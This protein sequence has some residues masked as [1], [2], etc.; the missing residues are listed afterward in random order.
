MGIEQIDVASGS[1]GGGGGVVVKE[2]EDIDCYR[3]LLP[4]NPGEML[5]LPLGGEFLTD[6]WNGMGA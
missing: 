2:V 1:G 4:N 6:D 3:V 5:N